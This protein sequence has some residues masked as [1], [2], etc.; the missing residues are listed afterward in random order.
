MS[1]L[2]STKLPVEVSEV[3]FY[4]LCCTNPD[5]RLERTSNGELIIM[6]PTG[7]ETGERNDELSYQLRTWN[8]RTGLGKCFNAATGFKLPNGSYRSPDA[9]WVRLDRWEALTPEERRGFPPLAPDFVVELRSPTD[10]LDKLQKKMQEYQ[11]NGVRLGY[12]IV[13]KEITDSWQ[14]EIYRINQPKEVIQSPPSLS[15]EDVLPGLVLD[16]CEI[17]RG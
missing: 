8:K 11:D 4:D 10:K 9:S 3:A 12:L 16:L 13:P 1:I 6:P 7:G 2:T 14:V 15:G 17:L 5:L